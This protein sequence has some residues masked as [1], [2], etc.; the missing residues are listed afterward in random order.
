MP[1][2]QCCPIEVGTGADF[3][4]SEFIGTM[5]DYRKMSRAELLQWIAQF[6]S[7]QAARHR[8]RQ[9][10]SAAALDD[11]EARLRAILATAVEGIVTISE[12]GIIESFNL[13]AEKMF[14][15]AAA[16]VI[17]QNV[18]VLMPEPHH[19][20][21]DG[22]LANYRGTG[23]ARIIGIGREVT[24]RRKNGG[25][26]PMDLS[27]SE[28]KLADRRIFTGF[29]RDITERKQLEKEILEISEREQRRIGHDLH[30]GI[31]QHL[32]GIELMSQVLE[33]KLERRSK[34][35]S[36]RAGAIA[37][38]V[39]ETISQ[40]R[41]LA[42]G[43]SPVTLEAEG[44]M[45]ALHELARNTGNIFRVTCQFECQ[46]PVLVND[47]AVS[48]HLF[49]IAQEAVSNAL[50]HGKKV[51]R[52][53]IQ[54]VEEADRLILTVTDDGAGFP[55]QLATAKSKGMGLRIM[56]SRTGMIGG[57][58]SVGNQPGGGATV[59]IAVPLA[60]PASLHHHGRE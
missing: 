35:G 2:R 41:A 7:R 40:T 22:Y 13:A 39:R 26:F 23:H 48:T 51:R 5:K 54:L 25:V 49:R 46:P 55:P 28:V 58:L 59:T 60:T 43:L 16:E 31:C 38:N 42:R 3:P 33:Q 53:T 10:K 47:Q 52:V 19:A 11:S 37:Q 17:G 18:K 44:L 14:G 45:S 6:K 24:G 12:R 56:Q 4:D 32:A 27:V 1:V 15:Y 29:I 9:K 57:T 8:V 21:H 20:L 36:A 34:D 50:R 30:D